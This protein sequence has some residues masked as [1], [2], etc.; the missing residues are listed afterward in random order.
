MIQNINWLEI[1]YDNFLWVF[2]LSIATIFITVIFS[3]WIIKH[4][5]GTKVLVIRKATGQLVK[6]KEIIGEGTCE[7]GKKKYKIYRKQSPSYMES[8]LRPFRLYV[9]PEGSSY[10]YSPQILGEKEGIELQDDDVTFQKVLRAEVIQQAVRGLVGSTLEKIIF[11]LAGGCVA[12]F[13]WEI[14]R[15]IT[16]GG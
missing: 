14:M 2:Y 11:A 7:F 16:S 3:T 8:F 12:I 15:A 6:A 5:I 10:V 13:I 9:H 1:V 4:Q